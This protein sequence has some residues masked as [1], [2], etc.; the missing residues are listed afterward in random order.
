MIK[1]HV[2]DFLFF[3]DF[4]VSGADEP[5]LAGASPPKQWQA[6]ITK[7]TWLL[8]NQQKLCVFLAFLGCLVFLV[9]S[10]DAPRPGGSGLAQKTSQKYQKNVW[11]FE[12]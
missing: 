7:N 12:N 5:R 1:K 10:T 3:I 8:E 2:F 6:R 4:L 11:F 9:C